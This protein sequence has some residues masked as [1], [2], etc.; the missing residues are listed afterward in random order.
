MF[1]VPIG[2]IGAM[3]VQRTPDRGFRV[4]AL[5]GLGFFAADCLYACVGVFGLNFILDFLLKYQIFFN[6]IGG[7]FIG[8]YIRW[9][10][11]SGV[12][13]V[14]KRRFGYRRLSCLNKIFGII[15]I[16]FAA[17]IF[18]KIILGEVM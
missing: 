9:G 13:C 1:G 5:T 8:T 16:L 14:I 7:V 4:G 10:T 12:V 15:L 11:L 2:A 6:I 3:T 17:M 18:G